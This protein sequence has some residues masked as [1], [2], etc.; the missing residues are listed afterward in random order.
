MPG[1]KRRRHKVWKEQDFLFQYQCW[2]LHFNMI[3]NLEHTTAMTYSSDYR[4][5]SHIFGLPAKYA[6]VARKAVASK[7]T[8]LQQAEDV[9]KL[10][11]LVS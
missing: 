2:F 1:Q 3:M 7:W 11:L 4:L 6:T 9:T 10:Y 5:K 8:L